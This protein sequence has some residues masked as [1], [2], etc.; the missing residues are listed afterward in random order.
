MAAGED[1][2]EPLVTYSQQA[3]CAEVRHGRHHLGLSSELAELLPAE[4]G[5]PQPVDRAVAGRSQQPRNRI[6]RHRV[7]PLAQ[8]E[9]A[10]VLQRILGELEITKYAD[11]RGEHPVTVFAEYPLQDR[12]RAHSLVA[13]TFA[14]E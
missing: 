6:V 2:A 10:R 12:R 7:A 5:A 11:Q 1:Q 4:P 13:A 8:S 9:R 3:V 14:G